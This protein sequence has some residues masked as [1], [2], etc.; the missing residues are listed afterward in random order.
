MSNEQI[1]IE[2]LYKVL[3]ELEAREI[4]ANMIFEEYFGC[5]WLDLCE[6]GIKLFRRLEK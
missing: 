1:I 3:A 4:G 2:E 6:K 5:S